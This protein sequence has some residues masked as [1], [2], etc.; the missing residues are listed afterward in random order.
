LLSGRVL[1][2]G[3]MPLNG[4]LAN[5]VRG[6]R[7]CRV[8]IDTKPFAFR[9]CNGSGLGEVFGAAAQIPGR[10]ATSARERVICLWRHAVSRLTTVAPAEGAGRALV[11]AS[12]LVAIKTWAG[13]VT[14]GV[15]REWGLPGSAGYRGLALAC[16]GRSC[17][18]LRPA[19]CRSRPGGAKLGRR[20]TK[21]P[22]GP[23]SS[24]W[25][26]ATRER[27]CEL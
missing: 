22:A 4:R 7:R 18:L 3:G 16:A 1:V 15:A 21:E 10:A 2:D 11:R 6:L 12:G 8:L 5:G 9:L 19:A 14:S 27:R 25:P 26:S 24:A 23:A 13:P 17:Y 20:G